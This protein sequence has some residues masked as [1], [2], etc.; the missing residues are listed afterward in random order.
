MP[1][2]LKAYH[3]F[4]LLL[5]ITLASV[6]GLL[7]IPALPMLDDY[8]GISDEKAQWTIGI[9]LIGYCIGQL[10]YGPLANRFG[11]KKAIYCGIILT[12]IGSLLSYFSSGF[13]MLCIAR[14]IQALGA[15]AGLKMSFTI[16]ADLLSG[17]EASKVVSLLSVAFGLMPGLAVATGGIIVSLFGW[18]GCFLFLSF[19]S[20]AVGLFS[21]CLPE[22]GKGCDAQALHPKKIM[23]GYLTQ[24]ADTNLVLNAILTSLSTMMI[25]LFATLAPYLAIQ[26]MHMSPSQFGGWNIIPASGLILGAFLSGYF[27]LRLTLKRKVFLGMTIIISGVF[28]MTT[29]FALGYL[30]PYSLFIGQFLIQS[31]Y[32]LVW[33]NTNTAALS[34][35]EDK[36]NAASVVQFINVGGSVAATFLIG[37]FS[38]VETLLLP[39]GF[40]IIV[41]LMVITRFAIMRREVA[42]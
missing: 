36:S 19:Y 28:A 6:T 8:F 21:L 11:R 29:A 37:F 14:L 40:C 1:G 30:N 7:F 5:L 33:A 41:T 15:A 9:F 16:V 39:F 17:K 20:L 3:I 23:R 18:R 2:P 13:S 22:T 12:I 26:R 4:T 24:L 31:G 38:P 32:N 25:Y 35:A 42:S 10:P 34:Y 27:S